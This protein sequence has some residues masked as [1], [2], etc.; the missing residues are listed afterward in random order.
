MERLGV[1]A[2]PARVG[3]DPLGSLVPDLASVTVAADVA[4]LPGPAVV[5]EA[6]AASLALWGGPFLSVLELVAARFGPRTQVA[7]L[8]GGAF[9]P[10]GEVVAAA[11]GRAGPVD[12]GRELGRGPVLG[13]SLLPLLD[14][15]R[16]LLVLL[17]GAAL[18][19]RDDWADCGLPVA[20]VYRLAG[21]AQAP[22]AGWAEFDSGADLDGLVE[23][24]ADPVTHLRL[25]A[26]G[27]VAAAWDAPGLEWERGELAG[28]P[29]GL[30][31]ARFLRLP[32]GAGEPA[33]TVTHRS[34]RR[35]RVALRPAELPPGPAPLELSPP[36][37]AVLRQWS[38]GRGF[39]CAGC[40][41][42]HE[43]GAVDCRA[44]PGS[45]L[46]SLA[47]GV[48]EL[49][50]E[51]AGWLARSAPSGVVPLD[52][53][54]LLGPHPGGARLYHW[55]EAGLVPAEGEVPRLPTSR[56]GGLVV[57]AGRSA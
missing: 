25:G 47:A 26:P 9:R 28:N 24:L 20:L 15:P 42:T 35:Q 7:F 45:L 40:R 5:V 27:L 41:R 55:T 2:R 43:P 32:G 56:G 51:G 1:L 37:A 48:Y 36:E 14:S 57:V 3:T 19:D 21:D 53:E 22:A 33:A 38:A 49:V 8:G 17:G 54:L 30:A 11:D 23:R 12:L 46:P 6:T 34:G 4:A 52:G 50:A 13:P 10:I 29:T 18:I 44:G 39:Y 31:S 16:P